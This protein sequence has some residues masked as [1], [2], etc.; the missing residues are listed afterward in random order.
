M[1]PDRQ[2]AIQYLRAPH[3]GL[4]HWAESG[5]VLVWHDGTTIAFREE[6]V[7]II[8]WL[9]PNGLPSFGAIVFLLAACRG[10]VPTVMDLASPNGLKQFELQIAPAIDQLQKVSQLPTELISGLKAK[11]VLAEAVFEP[12]KVGRYVEAHAAL[13]LGIR[14][15]MT[16]AD[17]V[18]CESVA[19]R[20]CVPQICIIS[21]GLKAHTA[22]SLA[23]RLQ[24]GLDALPK[25]ADADLPAAERARR[26]IEELSRD[27]EFGAVARAA[28]ELMAAV[29]LPRRL[30]EREQLAIGGVADITN[31]GPLDRLLLSELAHDD[32]TLS[33]RVALNEALYLRREPPMREPPG[34]LAILLD[35][36]VRL[37]G[38]PRALATA[39]ALALIARDKQHSEILAWRAHGKQ[40]QPVDLLSR[41][42][43]TQHLSV[44]EPAAHAGDSVP[45]F[46]EAAS[47]NENSQSVLITHRDALG[48]PEFRRA[49]A[50]NPSAPGF[51]A[52]VDR[53]GH[54]ELHAMPL[55]HRPPVCEA[56]L[57][58]ASVFDEN[59]GV[60]PIKVE[61]EPNLPAI[62]GISP[63]PFLLP[64]TGQAEFWTKGPD[65]L[66]TYAVLNDRRLVRYG[67]QQSG[68]RVL[69]GNLPGGKT[70]WMECL[71]DSAE[72][73][74]IKADASQRPARLLSLSLPYGN[75]RVT[76]LMGGMGVEPVRAV[77]RYADT[78]LVIRLTDVRA[79]S[80]SDGRMLGKALIAHQWVNG[81]YFRGTNHFYFAVWDGERVKFEPVHLPTKTMFSSALTIFDRPSH[82]G[83][84]VFLEN[85]HLLSLDS[86]IKIPAIF[87]PGPEL[88]LD[89]NQGRIS[90]D[91]DQLLV[92]GTN[93]TTKKPLALVYS[94]SER[95]AKFDI[96]G[97]P[98]RFFNRPPA[99]PTWNIYRAIESVGL[100]QNTVELFGRNARW[101]KLTLNENG[102]LC[103]QDLPSIGSAV[104][105]KPIF[106]PA[107]QAKDGCV[108]RVAELEGGSKMYL[109]SRGLLHFKSA[110]PGL[111]E[112]S[113]VLSDGE[114]AGWTSDG[115]V[116]GPQFFFEE[117][118]VSNP[119]GVFERI[120]N[121]FANL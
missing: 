16:D 70:I 2:Q 87:P 81:R 24:T 74:A 29:R 12:A 64:L 33:V 57:D 18:D 46:A 104:S 72:V 62:F 90:I 66:F 86:G 91:G 89:F 48:D 53:A 20:V 47:V 41:K 82:P 120:M 93:P 26:L 107:R 112:V 11:C 119:K 7:R 56:D 34:A 83:P 79:H 38:V 73:H 37:W 78:I 61:V 49:L 97:L 3:D 40:L 102:R 63:L 92:P 105:P 94:I 13:R 80:L 43:L 22:E 118:I 42:G 25:E 75:L 6:V 84:W 111:P 14:A 110:N 9:A 10:K 17:L 30:A 21:A 58:L 85:R 115:L 36:G 5:A 60:K 95:T 76:D 1:N 28:R 23:L 31:R 35:S 19:R 55:A 67:S 113:I 68:A 52:T 99:F 45:A 98:W 39:V 50:D 54:F 109:D 71:E 88:D 65:G 108:L 100:F 8:E 121:F 106:G 117:P 96:V 15:P 101:R 32:L 51:I 116:C 27:R 4:W 44:L 103:I 69:A 59:V 77:Y 114:V